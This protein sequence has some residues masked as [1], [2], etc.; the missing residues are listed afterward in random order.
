M[1]SATGLALTL[2]AGA[3]TWAVR[4]VSVMASMLS[5]MPLWKG[6]DPLPLLS[7]KK[8]SR[9]R[10]EDQVNPL[11]DD[12]RIAEELAAKLLNTKASS[13]ERP[14]GEDVI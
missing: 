6:F 13:E 14:Q 2:S 8:V 11:P 12:D 1:K 3:V 4:G 9:T 10:D 7:A 5:S